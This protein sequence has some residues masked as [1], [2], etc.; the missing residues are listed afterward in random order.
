VPARAGSRRGRRRRARACARDRSAGPG[1]G[2]SAHEPRHLAHRA[3]AMT[4]PIQTRT[5]DRG[6]RDP[7]ALVATRQLFVVI[8]AARPHE[9]GSRHALADLDEIEIGRGTSYRWKRSVDGAVRKLRIDIPDEW[10]SSVHATI[11][12]RVASA[13]IADAGS[14]NGTVVNGK[15]AQGAELADGDIIETGRTVFC[16]AAAMPAPPDAAID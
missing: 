16:F 15:L 3:R 11:K 6:S 7:A 2:R 1:E 10:M 8:Q 5:L 9:G 14:K 13:L 12:V 4:Q